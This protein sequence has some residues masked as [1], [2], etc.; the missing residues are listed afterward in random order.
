MAG[1]TKSEIAAGSSKAKRLL[2]TDKPY[3]TEKDKE[4]LPGFRLPRVRLTAMGSAISL[5]SPPRMLFLM[6]TYILLFWLMAGGIYI[7]VRNP[8]ALGAD[9]AGDPMYFYPSLN[10]AFILEGYIASIILFIGGFGAIM[11]YQAS[12]QSY[13]KAYA[14][15]IMVIGLIMCAI[16]FFVLQWIINIKLGLV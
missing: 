15:K 16:A 14:I 10:E 6:A 5:P 9:S 11:L 3:M 1:K 7:M 12:L 8:I 2:K 4:L 13:N